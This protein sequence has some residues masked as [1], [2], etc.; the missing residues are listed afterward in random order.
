MSAE[1]IAAPATISVQGKPFKV[2]RIEEHFSRAMD[3]ESVIVTEEQGD[4][5]KMQPTDISGKP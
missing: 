2:R 5:R 4:W 3:A 1:L